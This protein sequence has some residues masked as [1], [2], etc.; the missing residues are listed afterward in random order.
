MLGII[1]IAAPDAVALPPTGV[2]TPRS[3]SVAEPPGSP[4]ALYL[5]SPVTGFDRP[6][7]ITHAGDG[8]G[9]L[10]VVEQ[11]G[12]I[13]IV[14]AGA[15]EPV[16][17]LD[18][19]NRVGCGGGLLSVAFSP[20]Y[21]TNGTFY[22]QYDDGA[23]CDAVVARFKVGDDPNVADPTSFEEVLRV[24]GPQPGYHGHSGGQVAFGPDGY[25]YMA[26]GDGSSSADSAQTAQN[27]E[28]L[29]GKMLRLDVETGD[30]ATYTV[31]PT[32]PFV[33]VAGY[34]DEIWASGFRNPW[35]FSFDDLTGDLVIGD[36]GER[37][38][39]EINHQP[40]GSPGG[41]NYGW[42]LVEGRVC[43][44]PGCNPDLFTPPVHE[45]GH[46]QGCS[47]TGG[48]TYRGA[49]IPDL[50][51]WFL[52]G[53]FCSGRI[54]GVNQASGWPSVL[55]KDTGLMVVTFGIDQLGEPWVADHA[56]GTIYQL[57]GTVPEP[58]DL[59]VSQAD[60][61]DPLATGG[62]VTYQM[63]V[64]NQGAAPALDVLAAD[65][66]PAAATYVSA[67]PDQGRCSKTGDTVV[68]NLGSLAAGQSVEVTVKVR[69]ST[70]GVLTNAVSVSS[71]GPDPQPANDSSMAT[72]TVLDVLPSV[73]VADSRVRELNTGTATA[74]FGVSLSRAPGPGQSVTVKY[75]TADGTASA[76]SDY[77]ATG[78]T[79]LTFGEG[80]TTKTVDVPVKGDNAAE[81]DET[82][83]LNLSS[84][85]GAVM[86]DAQA[87]G[88]IAD[89]EG[90]PV[91][92]LADVSVLE[93]Q[94]GPTVV[95]FD[96]KLSHPVPAGA[97]ASVA[98]TTANLTA[99]APGDY[100]AVPLTTLTFGP[101]EKARTVNVTVNGDTSAEATETLLVKLSSPKGAV[102]GDSQATGSIVNDDGGTGAAPLP[103]LYVADSRVRELTRASPRL[104][105]RCRCRPLRVPG[106]ASPSRT[107]PPTAPL[108]LPV[109]TR[110]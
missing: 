27:P 29:W 104:S 48:A 42:S 6:V 8:S 5:T 67:R 3:A 88:R 19:T 110:P 101:G 10:F 13:R 1:V 94:G 66:L 41:E 18:V 17:F 64:T 57:T 76:P 97:T 79:T 46:D 50:D 102:L 40:G 12:R 80:Q 105:S 98:Y 26:L 9:R 70:S 99:K 30:P 39:E 90:L 54:W 91:V 37:Q 24:E 22:V 59:S 68:C 69:A 60:T 86:G 93:G 47:I 7:H 92:Y 51:G 96:V 14:R 74:S 103:S 95:G 49:Q 71:N 61:P 16:P 32:N 89:E 81:G 53:D 15:L 85:V 4:P 34:A 87:T 35:R 36:V 63:T 55:L 33:G 100:G 77:L 109:T 56:G 75:A 52:Y 62:V 2:L 65:Q 45:Y 44:Q 106:R 31:P 20:A 82:F 73:Y 107:S 78:L 21:A 84:P 11:P 28:V 25:L 23:S 83:L 43:F 108:P 58:V 38:S 72:T